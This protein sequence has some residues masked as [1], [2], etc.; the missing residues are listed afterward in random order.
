[1]AVV[2]IQHDNTCV[3]GGFGA[4]CI[5]GGEGAEEEAVAVEVDVDGLGGVFG[6]GD[7]PVGACFEGIAVAGGMV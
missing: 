5:F 4:G 7:G 2:D 6:K 3:D 1:M